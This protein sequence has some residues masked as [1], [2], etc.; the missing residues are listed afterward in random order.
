MSGKGGG[1]PGALE[2]AGYGLAVAAGF[3]GC[4]GLLSGAAPRDWSVP[5]GLQHLGDF[6]LR[7]AI[8]LSGF[9]LAFG[10]I[11]LVAAAVPDDAGGE[12]SDR[13]PLRR[14]AVRIESDRSGT[15]DHPLSRG[16]AGDSGRA[17][18]SAG[19]EHSG[20]TGASVAA[21]DSDGA[22]GSSGSSATGPDTESSRVPLAEPLYGF[23][24]RKDQE[25]LARATGYQPLLFTKLSILFSAAIGVLLAGSF[26][27]AGEL[28][29]LPDA[30]AVRIL[31]GLYLMAESAHR[32]IRFARGAPSGTLAGW[33]VSGLAAAIPGG[34]SR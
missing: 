15:H 6:G 7:T 13:P 9:L 26:D 1:R 20:A 5:F 2:L 17:G 21:E 30:A 28:E 16:A 19:A 24:P 23:L 29:A 4:L 12:A 27:F 18:D 8:Y 14:G 31:L 33:L 3:P 22:G 34:R 10:A 11:G 25:R 32:Y